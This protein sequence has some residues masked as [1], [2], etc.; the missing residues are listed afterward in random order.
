[1]RWDRDQ[2]KPVE[3]YLAAFPVV[4]ASREDALVLVCGEYEL[5]EESARHEDFLSRFPDW[6]DWLRLQLVFQDAFSTTDRPRSLES[7]PTVG[8]APGLEQKSGPLQVPGYEILDELGRGGM[9]VVYRAR[10]VKANR[11]VALK[12]IRGGERAGAAELARFKTEGE[13]IA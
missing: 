10:Q 12:M 13:A 2:G 1:E 3:D 11:H 9:G 8:D 5:Q 6:A 4:A 7:A